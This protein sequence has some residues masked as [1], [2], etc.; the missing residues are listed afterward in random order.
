[1]AAMRDESHFSDADSSEFELLSPKSLVVSSMTDAAKRRGDEFSSEEP[2]AAKQRP[3]LAKDA[4]KST[5]FPPGI[6][7]VE[8]WGPTILTKGKYSKENLT[9][10]EL[11]GDPDKAK[12][13][14]CT[15][16]MSQKDPADLN[17]FVS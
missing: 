16:M 1:M 8:E 9:Y 3:L 14:Y 10:A 7:S 4:G 5:S 6:R 17:P 13:A 11:S 15:W 2:P 12:Q